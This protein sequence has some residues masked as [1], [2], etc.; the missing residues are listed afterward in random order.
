MENQKIN[1]DPNTLVGKKLCKVIDSDN[2]HIIRIKDVLNGT[3]AVFFDYSDNEYKSLNITELKDF[4]PLIPDGVCTFNIV[5]IISG[6][7]EDDFVYD[8]LVTGTDFLRFQMKDPI[9]FCICR[10]CANDIFDLMSPSGNEHYYGI[11]VSQATCPKGISFTDYLDCNELIYSKVVYFYRDDTITD[12]LKFIDT[13]PYDDILNANYH[14]HAISK[15]PS[16]E[17]KDYD[18]GWCCTLSRLLTDN[19]FQADLDEMFAV[20]TVDFC[21][22]DHMVEKLLP[23]SIETYDSITD[24]LKKWLSVTLNVAMNDVTVLEYYHDINMAD[25]KNTRYMFI[26]DNENKLYILVYTL[27]GEHHLADL[28]DE[29][30]EKNKFRLH[31]YNKYNNNK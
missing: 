25:F 12:I 8:V 27:D 5:K 17:L 24:N 1:I 20:L 3:T 7:S 18:H 9:P 13:E 16:F 11:S 4:S 23:G 10:Q 28:I 26:R 19:N 14:I 21:M 31:I 30:I 22:K 29:D 6:N 2:I 15:D